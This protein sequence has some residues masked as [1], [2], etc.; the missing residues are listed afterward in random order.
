MIYANGKLLNTM[1]E[2]KYVPYV[3][4]LNLKKKRRESGKRKIFVQM[5][6]LPAQKL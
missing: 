5:I 1:S 6:S 4:K 3:G 2:T